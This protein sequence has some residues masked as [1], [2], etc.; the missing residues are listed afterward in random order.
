M[1]DR[2][3]GRAHVHQYVGDLRPAVGRAPFGK[4]D[5]GVIG[6]QIED[7]AAAAHGAAVLE[8]LQEGQGER[9]AL[10]IDRRGR[11]GQLHC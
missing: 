6:E 8:G 11:R 3:D 7:T 9:L 5:L 2:V 10:F 4:A 1:A